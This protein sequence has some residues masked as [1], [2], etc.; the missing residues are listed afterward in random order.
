MEGVTHFVY[1]DKELAKITEKDE[2]AQYI[3][4]FEKDDLENIEKKFD[5]YGLSIADFIKGDVKES[6]K[7]GAKTK[8]KVVKKSAKTKEALLKPKFVIENDKD[9]HELFSLLEVLEFVRSQAQKGVHIQRYKGLGE[10]NP[11]QL[12]D[13]TMDPEHRT[14]LKVVLEDAVVSGGNIFH[15][16]GG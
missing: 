16:D 4:I 8:K 9:K 13:T 15:T 3:E 12:W 6:I 7:D 5:K 2:E 11:Q 14:I 10:M 1:D